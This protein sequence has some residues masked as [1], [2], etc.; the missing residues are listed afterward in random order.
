VNWSR[1]QATDCTSAGGASVRSQRGTKAGLAL[2]GTIPGRDAMDLRRG[3]STATDRTAWLGRGAASM[4]K[5]KATKTVWFPPKPAAA[6]KAASTGKKTAKKAAKKT[7][8][9]V[10]STTSGTRA[11]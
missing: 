9:T 5:L 6:G 3:L 8:R 11:R 2:T 7:T 10:K 4:A 1:T